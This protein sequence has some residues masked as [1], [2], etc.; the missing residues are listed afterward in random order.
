[1]RTSPIEGLMIV[2]TTPRCG[3]TVITAGIASALLQEG[4]QVQAIKPL[5]FRP[6]MVIRQSLDQPFLNKATR[7]LQ[8]IDP[9]EVESPYDLS[10]MNWA[11]VV[12]TAR[13]MVFPALIEP[14]GTIGAALRHEGGSV[15]DAIELAK[16]LGIPVLIVTPKSPTLLEQAAPAFAYLQQRQG[17]I[18][19][20]IGWV[21]VESKPTQAPYWDNEAF[22]LSGQ[23]RLP[24]LGTLPYSPHI[25][26]ESMQI[27]DLT[28]L[29]AMAIDLLPL[30][31]ALKIY[32]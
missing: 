27:G 16:L 23:Y 12:E 26:V 14:P 17:D 18:P 2:S 7:T 29:T 15:I 20:G 13:K 21:G 4:L 22:Y 25:S 32:V 3:K 8:Q 24:C 5:D 6:P 9:I 28:E 10:N 1:M 11:R 31:Q 19:L 30:Q